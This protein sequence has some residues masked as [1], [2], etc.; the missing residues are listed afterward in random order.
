M[1]TT[2]TSELIGD[3]KLTFNCTIG[4][5]DQSIKILCSVYLTISDINDECTYRTDIMK[6]QMMLIRREAKS[7]VWLLNG[8]FSWLVLCLFCQ[9]WGW[10][11]R[12]NKAWKAATC[13]VS[14]HQFMLRH[15]VNI[16]YC[17]L[18]QGRYTSALLSIT[19]SS[20]SIPLSHG[21]PEA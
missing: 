8:F 11:M 12:L 7:R 5:N 15:S 21:R 6:A 2:A 13:S 18:L 4:V 17:V 1:I 19:I 3:T 14:V 16:L 20:S 9:V 10:N